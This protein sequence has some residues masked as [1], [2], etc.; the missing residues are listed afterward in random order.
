MK[1]LATKT[2]YQLKQ[3]IYMAMLVLY[4]DPDVPR[5]IDPDKEWDSGTIEDVAQILNNIFTELEYKAIRGE[6]I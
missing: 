3:T 2:K 5:L 4:G 1:Y 6:S